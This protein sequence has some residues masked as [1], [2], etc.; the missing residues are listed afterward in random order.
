MAIP[1]MDARA[2]SIFEGLLRLLHVCCGIDVEPQHSVVAEDGTVLA[3]G[4]LL[5]V[6]TRMLHEL[7]GGHHRS[8]VQ[9]R[10]DLRR[11]RRLLTAGYERRAFTSQDVLLT[12]I[13]ILRDAEATLGREHDPARIQAWYSLLQ[14][15]L[16]SPSGQHRLRLRLA[17][18]RENAEEIPS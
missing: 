16:L 2:E 9:Q 10:K 8:A 6:G 17:L 11:Q 7:D 13:G 5:L 1:L 12:P 18:D 3:R 4:D 15:S 14:E